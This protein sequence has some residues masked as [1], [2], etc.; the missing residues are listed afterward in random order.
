MDDLID[1][2][3]D[4]IPE[5]LE[6]PFLVETCGCMSTDKKAFVCPKHYGQLQQ[7]SFNAK[8]TSNTLKTYN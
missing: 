1:I 3:R 5:N 4:M 8:Q 2:L 6:E 7:N